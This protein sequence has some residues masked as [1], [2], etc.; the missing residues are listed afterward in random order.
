M[1]HF[2][3]FFP[4]SA[5]LQSDFLPWPA[6]SISHDHVLVPVQNAD[7][8]ALFAPGTDAFIAPGGAALLAPGGAGAAFVAPGGVPVHAP[9]TSLRIHPGSC[10][11]PRL[12]LQH[13]DNYEVMCHAHCRNARQVESTGGARFTPLGREQFAKC[14]A[15]CHT[16]EYMRL[17]HHGSIDHERL[18]EILENDEEFQDLKEELEAS[19]NE[20][21]YCQERMDEILEYY[22]RPPLYHFS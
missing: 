18:N 6:S 9:S 7:L 2:Q 15:S 8:D 19:N 1:S 17:L 3:L 10:A 13:G 5:S 22:N 16:C 21:T 14:I 12:R 11:H 20:C 4:T